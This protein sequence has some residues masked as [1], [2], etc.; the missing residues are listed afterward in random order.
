MSQ[1]NLTPLNKFKV[2][3]RVVGYRDSRIYKD[4]NGKVGIITED[5]A[6]YVEVSYSHGR[7]YYLYDELTYAKNDIIRQIIK[8]L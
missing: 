5:C 7:A 4:F 6:G 1:T 3:D 2:D 8:D